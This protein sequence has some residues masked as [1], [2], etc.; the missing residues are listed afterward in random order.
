MPRPSEVT[1]F[2]HWRRDGVV[3][4]GFF[5]FGHDFADSPHVGGVAN[6]L[7][8]LDTGAF[9][10]TISPAAAREVTKVYGDS[11]TVVK[12]ISGKVKKSIVQI[13]S[14]FSS[15]T[16]D[17]KTRIWSGYDTSALSDDDGAEVV[18]ASRF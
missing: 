13:R 5:R 16:C 4:A 3:H 18:G 2:L 9:N 17:R 12:G 14:F 15:D 1:G 6:K 8:L 11:N 7:F 10:N